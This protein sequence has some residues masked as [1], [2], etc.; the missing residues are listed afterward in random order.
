M[1]VRTISEAYT[2]QTS[3]C[4]EVTAVLEAGFLGFCSIAA[5]MMLNVTELG[6][7]HA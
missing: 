6:K 3:P 2:G 1:K 4:R 7:T 5:L